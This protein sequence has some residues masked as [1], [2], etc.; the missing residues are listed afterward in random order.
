MNIN[1]ES[2]GGSYICVLSQLY[3]NEY[4]FEDFFINDDNDD[5]EFLFIVYYSIDFEES[6]GISLFIERISL[7]QFRNSYDLRIRFLRNISNINNRY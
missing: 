1:L 3:F 4:D 5:D 7:Y 6:S 2:L